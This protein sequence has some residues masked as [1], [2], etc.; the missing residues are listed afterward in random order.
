MNKKYLEMLLNASKRANDKDYTLMNV[1]MATKESLILTTS[2]ILTTIQQIDELICNSESSKEFYGKVPELIIDIAR[3]HYENEFVSHLLLYS[4]LD[5][6][7]AEPYPNQ[8]LDILEKIEDNCLNGAKNQ[9]T[10]LMN[11]FEKAMAEP[12]TEPTPMPSGRGG[13]S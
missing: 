5:L 7:T 13:E 2:R 6:G 3:H 11:G 9:L 12:K 8:V 4:A 10:D 1:A